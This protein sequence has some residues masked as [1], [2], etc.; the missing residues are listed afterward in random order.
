MAKLYYG[1]LDEAG[2]LE[3][4]VD[5]GSHFIISA[6]IV[7]DLSELKRVMKFAK[8]KAQGKFKTHSI[9]KASKEDNGFV[10]IVLREL[11]KKDIA[12]IIGVWDKKDKPNLDKNIIYAK[13]IGQTVKKSLQVYPRLSLILHKRYTSPELRNKMNKIINETVE[14]G[15]FLAIEHRSE[16]EQRELELADAVAWAVYQKYSNKNLEFYNIIE[17][18]IKQENK[19]TA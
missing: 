12:I 11:S 14:T 5:E 8:R 10:K 3:K 1:L 4:K 19:L 7:G 17:G 13:L 9:F 6:I 16:I 18:K 15:Q 2:I